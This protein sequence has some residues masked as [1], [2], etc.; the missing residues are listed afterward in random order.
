MH[1]IPTQKNAHCAELYPEMM[2]LGVTVHEG[3]DWEAIPAGAPVISFV[4]KSFWLLSRRY[5]TD[6]KDS[7]RQLHDL[8]FRQG[9]GS[10]EAWRYFPVSLSK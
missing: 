4:M 5:E 3:Y 2:N 10:H 8:A 1:L 6:E 9:K 7:F